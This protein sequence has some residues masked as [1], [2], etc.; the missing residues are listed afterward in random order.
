MVEPLYKLSDIEHL[1]SFDEP[2]LFIARVGFLPAIFLKLQ[3]IGERGEFISCYIQEE[4]I[5]GLKD[6]RISIRGVF[7]A[8]KDAHIVE[9]DEYLNVYAEKCL[10]R[11]EIPESMLPRPNT[12]LYLRHGECPD[13]LQEKDALLSIYFR[14]VELNREH[15]LYSTLMSLLSSVQSLAR[16]VIAP[17]ELRGLRHSTFDFLVGDPALG[18][19]MISIKKPTATWEN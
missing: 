18:S 14:G 10:L 8:Q 7:E 4:Y 11:S 16:N 12:G 2:V 9:C 3:D 19:L 17:P 1:Y 15:I 5:D 6:G 13:V